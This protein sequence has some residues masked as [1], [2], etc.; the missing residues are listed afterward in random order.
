MLFLY[1]LNFTF[2]NRNFMI[3]FSDKASEFMMWTVDLLQC[4]WVPTS[5]TWPRWTHR[6][7]MLVVSSEECYLYIYSMKGATQASFI[8]PPAFRRNSEAQGTPSCCRKRRSGQGGSFSCHCLSHHSALYSPMSLPLL[9]S[10]C[11]FIC[12]HLSFFATVSPRMKTP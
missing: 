12:L 6:G 9:K 10:S 11:L 4:Q 5:V 1:P 8:Q 7:R 2:V 3:T